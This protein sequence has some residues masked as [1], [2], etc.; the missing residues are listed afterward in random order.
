MVMDL[1]GPVVEVAPTLLGA[2]LR[3]GGVAVRI[4]EVEAYDGPND[5]ASHAYRGP[6]ARNATMFGP[7]GHLY[8]Y[9]TYGMHWAANVV[10]GPDGH[11]SGALLRAGEVIEGIELARSRRGRS[12]DRDLARGPGRL[13]QAL[14]LT[15]AMR[16]AYLFGAGEVSLD[17]APDPAPSISI[18]PRVGVSAAAD[19]P[20]RFWITGDRYVSDYRRSPRAAVSS[21]PRR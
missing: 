10:C 20:W 19:R 5:P 15:G 8:L 9:F 3:H 16:G 7:P 1:S 21:A 18:G 11:A 14:H 17:P 13:C 4:T 6:T 12:P 2:T